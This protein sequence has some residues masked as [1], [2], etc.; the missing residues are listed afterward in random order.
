MSV[1]DD[2]RHY[3]DRHSAENHFSQVLLHFKP[4]ESDILL[5][6]ILIN[7]IQLKIVIVSDIL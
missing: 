2:A 6:I 1:D 4:L 3:P 5:K 7:V